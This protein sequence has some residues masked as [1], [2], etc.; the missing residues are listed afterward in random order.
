[1]VKSNAVYFHGGRRVDPLTLYPPTDEQFQA[2]MDFLRFPAG[3]GGSSAANECPLPIRASAWNRPRWDPYFAMK[4]HHIFR[5]RRER[6]LHEVNKSNSM[7]S[8]MHWPELYDSDFIRLQEIN[9]WYG[10]SVDEEGVKAAKERIKQ[11]APTSPQWR[12]AQALLKEDGEAAAD[13]ADAG[14][15]S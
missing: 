10:W 11:V 8:Y 12:H 7:W 9:Y 15:A 2:L 5:D 14:P 1:M 13:D 6:V 3:H 4:D